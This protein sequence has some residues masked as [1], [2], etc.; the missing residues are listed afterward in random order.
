MGL[1]LN[2]QCSGPPFLRQQV[3]LFAPTLVEFIYFARLLMGLMMQ[4]VCG[5]D[6]RHPTVGC[7]GKMAME[8]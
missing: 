8:V 2:W 5:A 3:V 6:G 4:C 7:A 1:D